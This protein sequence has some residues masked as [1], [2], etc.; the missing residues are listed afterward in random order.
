MEEREITIYDYL[1]VILKRKWFIMGIFFVATLTAACVSLLLPK[2]YEA[3]AILKIG[4]CAIIWAAKAEIY[5]GVYREDELLEGQDVVMRFLK[6]DKVLRELE[7]KLGLLRDA[8]SHDDITLERVGE[9]AIEIKAKAGTPILAKRIANTLARIAIEHHEGVA[10]RKREAF[11]KS[12]K[13]SMSNLIITIE[14]SEIL[15]SAAEPIHPVAP[16]KRRN[17]MVA[18]ILSLVSA[19]L[20]AFFLEGLQKRG[21]SS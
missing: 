10:K 9:D 7:R 4:R 20:I 19:V 1:G 5:P 14:P 21:E 13:G 12:W 2:I 18:G 16:K 17:V 8:I 3:T 11:G 6:G 15:L